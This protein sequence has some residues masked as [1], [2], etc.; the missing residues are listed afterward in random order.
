VAA[1]VGAAS[2]PGSLN[3]HR[4][5]P[6]MALL[7]TAMQQWGARCSS[8][9]RA[10]RGGVT[11]WRPAPGWGSSRPAHSGHGPAPRGPADP[12]GSGV[13][14][15]SSTI[16]RWETSGRPRQFIEMWLKSRCSTPPAGEG[17]PRCVTTRP[18]STSSSPASGRCNGSPKASEGVR[19]NPD[20]VRPYTTLGGR[21]VPPP[22]GRRRPGPLLR[23]ESRP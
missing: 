19:R 22:A 4:S 13:A 10:S 14:A 16:T 11:A 1:A 20:Q 7:L 23:C 5:W 3:V 8:T 18:A 21:R 12:S 9:P 15:I 2:R 17:L 6:G